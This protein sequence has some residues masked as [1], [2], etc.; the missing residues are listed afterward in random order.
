[1]SIIEQ[2]GGWGRV[3]K[4]WGQPGLYRNILSQEN[5]I[6][7]EEEGVQT[8]THIHTKTTTLI[9]IQRWTCSS[10]EVVIKPCIHTSQ[11]CTILKMKAVGA[12]EMAEWFKALAALPEDWVQFPAHMWQFTTVCNSCSKGSD[13][14]IQTYMQTKHNAHKIKIN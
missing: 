4:V 7:K 1:M 13:T 3:T 10:S 11:T 14:L 6:R 2:S 12:G 5:K 8:H 9:N